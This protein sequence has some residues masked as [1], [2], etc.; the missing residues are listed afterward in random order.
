MTRRFWLAVSVQVIILLLMVGVHGF[1]LM[2]GDPVL[3]KTAP[4]DYWDPFRG[5][6][7]E[8]AYEISGIS[9]DEVT[10]TGWP[11]TEGQRV[12]VT[13]QKGQPYWTAVAISDRKPGP[14]PDQVALRG[15][16]SWIQPGIPGESII[17]RIWL[18]YGIEQFYVPEGQGEDLQGRP[19][20][21]EVEALVDATGRAALRAVYLDGKPIEWR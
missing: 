7:I 3:L 5:Q 2:T 13:L 17:D 14:G 16:I 6:Y 18:R 4:F 8:L 10:L 11:Y 19:V 21:M 1:T 12:W 20:E 9:V 15:R